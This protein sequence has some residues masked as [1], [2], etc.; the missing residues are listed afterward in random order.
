MRMKGC[1][2]ACHFNLWFISLSILWSKV[3]GVWSLTQCGHT[4]RT[5]MGGDGGGV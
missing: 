3:G 5:V 2:F 1:G 4:H